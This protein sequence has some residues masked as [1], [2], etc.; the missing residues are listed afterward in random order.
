MPCHPRQ[1]GCFRVLLPCSRATRG[2]HIFSRRRI[3]HRRSQVEPNQTKPNQTKPEKRK[4]KREKT[5]SRCHRVSFDCLF[6]CFVLFCFE[7]SRFVVCFFPHLLAGL[8]HSSVGFAVFFHCFCFTFVLFC[9]GWLCGPQQPA[10][11]STRDCRRFGAMLPFPSRPPP[12][13]VLV[14]VFSSSCPPPP[15]C[16][17]STSLNLATRVARA[18][19]VL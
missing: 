9:I 13:L 4:R 8:G 1:I 5:R 11:I 12:F 10:L 15:V 7:A 3:T 14:L 16:A 2:M 19:V 17:T 18:L 6:F